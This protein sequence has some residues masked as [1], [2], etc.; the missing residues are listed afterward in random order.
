MTQL[1]IPSEAE[2]SADGSAQSPDY[3]SFLSGVD[4]PMWIGGEPVPAASGQWR[5]V[6]NPAKRETV[7]ARVPASGPEDVDRAVS[8]ARAAFPGWRS[9]HFTVRSRALSLI[10]DEIEARAEDFARLTAL[11]TGNALRTQARP[12]VTTLVALFRFFA[13]IAGEVKGVTL[14]AGEG[15]LQYTRLEPLGV[16]ACILP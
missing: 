10:A 1:N 13:G 5:D 2:R 9:A 16:V 3:S 11:D 7:I 14:P 4:Q 8:A 12:E 6:L 15:Q